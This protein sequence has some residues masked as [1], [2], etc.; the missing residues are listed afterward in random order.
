VEKGARRALLKKPSDGVKGTEETNPF[1]STELEPE[2]PC[3]ERAN[4]KLD[5]QVLNKK[6][7]MTFSDMIEIISRRSL[8]KS[9]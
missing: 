9:P 3:P 2:A 6:K 8:S 5:Q 7:N 1:D 4:H